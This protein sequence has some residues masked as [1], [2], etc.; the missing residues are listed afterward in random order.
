MSC[1][2]IARPAPAGTSA[3]PELQGSWVSGVKNTCLISPA[4]LKLPLENAHQAPISILFFF[5]L[6][7]L[8]ED[9]VSFIAF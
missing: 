4:G 1:E 9:S 6:L 3:N 2:L 8:L 7:G 5:F